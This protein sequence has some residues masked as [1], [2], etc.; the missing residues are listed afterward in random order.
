MSTVQANFLIPAELLAALRALV[1][2]GKESK[3]K[4]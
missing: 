4:L 2:K 3:A 1:P